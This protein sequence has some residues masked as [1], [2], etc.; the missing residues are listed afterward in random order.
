MSDPVPE[1]AEI[2]KPCVDIGARSFAAGNARYRAGR[3]SHFG[4]YA[5]CEF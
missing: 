5:T 2:A 4:F 3:Q 1:G